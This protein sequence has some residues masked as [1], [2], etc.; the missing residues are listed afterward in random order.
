MSI[1][2]QLLQDRE[3]G[4]RK[5]SV[6]TIALLI[7]LMSDE[8]KYLQILDMCLQLLNDQ[9]TQILDSLKHL[10]F[11]ALA[12]WSFTLHRLESDLFSKLL[13][14]LK[15]EKSLYIVN[16]IEILLPYLVMSVA[17]SEYLMKKASKNH[18]IPAKST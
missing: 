8:E 3:E 18:P 5:A 11:P 4:I 17:G 2:Q 9:S 6:N 16:V 12:Q 7:A 1:V 10:L 15:K 14:K 13:L